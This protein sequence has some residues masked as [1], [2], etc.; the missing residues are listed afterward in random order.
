MNPKIFYFVNDPEYEKRNAEI[1]QEVAGN[2][3]LKLP[4]EERENRIKS[5]VMR[6]ESGLYPYKT[7]VGAEVNFGNCVKIYNEYY[8]KVMKS[9]PAI[10]LFQYEEIVL[11][12]YPRDVRKK[13]VKVRYP[14]PDGWKFVTSEVVDNYWGVIEVEELM[15]EERLKKV[16]PVDIEKK[17][18]LFVLVK[19]M[20]EEELL[21]VHLKPTSKSL[22]SAKKCTVGTLPTTMGISNK[23]PMNFSTQTPQDLNQQT[24]KSQQSQSQQ[25]QQTQQNQQ[26]QQTQQNQQSQSQYSQSTSSTIFPQSQNFKPASTTL[27]QSHPNPLHPRY[28]TQMNAQQSNLLF[29]LSQQPPQINTPHPNPLF[30]LSQQNPH[31]NPLFQLSQMNAPPHPN[32]LFQLSQMN[33]PPHP[34]PLLQLSQQ[35]HPNPLFNQQLTNLPIQNTSLTQNTNISIISPNTDAKSRLQEYLLKKHKQAINSLL[36][37]DTQQEGAAFISRL[38]ISLENLNIQGPPATKKKDAEQ[39]VAQLALSKLTQQ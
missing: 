28:N 38:S 34:N 26:N 1:M 36:S 3:E 10:D 16:K 4:K 33:A 24:Q 15:E 19:T 13:L 21:D 39:Y 22:Y 9:A 12:S 32:P 20:V 8:Q 37:Y 25:N 11:R 27:V 7:V 5:N 30:H 29:Q 31:P 35:P 23:V 6:R 2:P 18:F 14:S 17:R